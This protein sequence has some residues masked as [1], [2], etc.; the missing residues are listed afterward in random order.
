VIPWLD[1]GDAPEDFPPVEAALTD[2]NGL[3]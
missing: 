3:L 1:A 2:P